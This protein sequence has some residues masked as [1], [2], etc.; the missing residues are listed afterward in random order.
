[1]KGLRTFVLTFVPSIFIAGFIQQTLMLGALHAH[2]PI[3]AIVP[4]AVLVLLISIAFAA[5]SWHARTASALNRTAVWIG[6][7]LIAACVAALVAGLLDLSP[8]IGGNIL[9]GLAVLLDIGFLVPAL[10]AVVI[11][12]WVLRRLMRH[13]PVI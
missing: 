12:W 3:S 8:G 6:G 4:L 11:H 7:L 10:I 2:E 13:G 1:M 9:V 5:V